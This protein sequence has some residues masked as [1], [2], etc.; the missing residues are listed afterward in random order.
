[1]IRMNVFAGFAACVLVSPALAEDMPDNKAEYCAQIVHH[2]TVEGVMSTVPKCECLYG[3][4]ESRTDKKVKAFLLESWWT[5]TEDTRKLNRLKRR[6][7]AQGQLE[8]VV[9]E[10]MM[11]CPAG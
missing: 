3:I 2:E 10:G 11:R 5:G 8:Q 1:M 9:L 4:V 7:S 6:K